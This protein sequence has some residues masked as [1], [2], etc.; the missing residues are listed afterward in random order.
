MATAESFFVRAR[1]MASEDHFEYAIEL[2]LDGL[3]FDP[4]NLAAHQALRDVGLQRKAAGGKDLSMLEKVKLRKP[5]RDAAG[6]LLNTEKLLAYDPGNISWMA[7]AAQHAK[8]ADLPR[9]T[10]YFLQLSVIA[11]S[12]NPKS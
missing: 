6:D 12:T 5:A 7:A 2:Y 10:Q 4:D 11:N 1:A 9:A 3:E 8:R